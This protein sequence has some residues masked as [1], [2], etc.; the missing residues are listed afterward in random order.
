MTE[1]ENRLEAVCRV[2]AN[3]AFT[4]TSCRAKYDPAR[5][6]GG[7]YR[8]FF[9]VLSE[10][11]PDD[12]VGELCKL[13]GPE[14]IPFGVRWLE[15]LHERVCEAVATGIEFDLREL[16]TELQAVDKASSR[17]RPKPVAK[18]IDKLAE[19]VAMVLGSAPEVRAFSRRWVCFAIDE[20]LD[21][22]AKHGA[23]GWDADSEGAA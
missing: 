1:D 20:S 11:L 15:W 18:A 17:T 23:D 12:A 7:E 22:T 21:Y 9:T 19:A 6:S 3:A 5:R 13:Y 16:G 14:I 10:H 4:L 8:L 2:A